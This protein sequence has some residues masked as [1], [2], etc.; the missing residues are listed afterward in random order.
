LLPLEVNLLP[1]EAE[2]L[3]VKI[4]ELLGKA[5]VPR[6]ILGAFRFVNCPF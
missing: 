5:D 6:Q 4:N 1:L 2:A 3:P